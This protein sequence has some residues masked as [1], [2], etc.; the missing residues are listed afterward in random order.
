MRSSGLSGVW[1]GAALGLAA[2]LAVTVLIVL[3]PAVPSARAQ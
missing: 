2:T 3:P 1:H